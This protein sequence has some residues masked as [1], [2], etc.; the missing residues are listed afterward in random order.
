MELKKSGKS[1]HD[2]KGPTLAYER[3][4][5]SPFRNH[6]II[7]ADNSGTMEFPVI[8]VKDTLIKLNIFTR[9]HMKKV[10]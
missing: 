10:I 8:V 9:M 3:K 5:V 4:V 2:N 1:C 7:K 6:K